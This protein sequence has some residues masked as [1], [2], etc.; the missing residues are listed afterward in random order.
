MAALIG[1]TNENPDF[2]E[3]SFK[4]KSSSKVNAI[5]DIDGV[6]AFRHPESSEG[7][8]ASFWLGGSYDEKPE[9]GKML[10]L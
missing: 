10:R 9:N 6:L 3:A 4:S 8:M 7:E 5:I 1:T 2:E